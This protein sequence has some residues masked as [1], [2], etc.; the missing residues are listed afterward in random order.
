MSRNDR[1]VGSPSRQSV[2][3]F[4]EAR[5][6]RITLGGSATGLNPLRAQIV[7]NLLLQFGVRVDWMGMGI[8]LGKG[9]QIGA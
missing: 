4:C 8:G 2:E 5:V 3:H 7:V 1:S 6:V 9:F